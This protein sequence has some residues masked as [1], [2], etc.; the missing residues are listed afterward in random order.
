MC[1]IHAIPPACLI[2][3]FCWP[4]PAFDRHELAWQVQHLDWKL[5][6]AKSDHLEDVKQ[7]KREQSLLLQKVLQ[8]EQR[9]KEL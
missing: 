6:V 3:I 9:A 2:P 1:T 4:R 7:K 5:R 8:L